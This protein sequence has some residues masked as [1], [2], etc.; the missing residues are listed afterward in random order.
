LSY[1]DAG[2]LTGIT[3][4]GS[5]GVLGLFSYGYDA[6]GNRTSA[7]SLAGTDAYS[8]DELDRL[9]GVVRSDGVAETYSYDAAGN[10]LS[11]TVGG[12]ATNNS[13]DIANQ[14][15]QVITSGVSTPY[16]YDAAGRLLDDGVNQYTWDGFGQLVGVSGLAGDTTYRYDGDGLRI[17][18]TTSGLTTS[19]LWDR[20]QGLPQVAGY[21]ATAYVRGPGSLSAV[22]GGVRQQL[23]IDGLASTRLVTDETGTITG[24]ADY[25]TYGEVASQTGSVGALGYTGELQ[26]PSGLLYLRARTY[27]PATGTFLSKDLLQPN[28]PGTQGWNPYNYVGNNPATRTDPSGYGELLEYV[29]THAWARGAAV[30]GV[31]GANSGVNECRTRSSSHGGYFSCVIAYTAISAGFGAGFGA[32]GGAVIG[33]ITAIANSVTSMVVFSF[34]VAAACMAGGVTGRVRDE[35]TSAI[36]GREPGS[37]SFANGCALGLIGFGGGALP[38]GAPAPAPAPEPAPAPVLQPAPNP[39]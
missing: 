6:A 15:T 13:Y 14:V 36:L 5:G 38:P 37:S 29:A 17:S 21:G 28:L 1:D 31:F 2:R 27:Q 23:L 25:S 24:T 7:T 32:I 12:A 4:T 20:A 33:P 3:H 26:D 8:Y 11:S 22:T 39:A 19:I 9:I 16:V 10:R 30:A 18:E 35:I 34:A